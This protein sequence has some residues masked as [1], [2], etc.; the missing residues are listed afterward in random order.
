MP[1]RPSEPSRAERRLEWIVGG[2]AVD[3]IRDPADGERPGTAAPRHA[4]AAPVA[5]VV[6]DPIAA[7]VGGWVPRTSDAMQ[8]VRTEYVAEHGHPVDRA[9]VPRRRVRLAITW[10]AAGAAAVALAL[11]GGAVAVRAAS[12]AAGPAVV[13]PV[14]APRH[15]AAPSACATSCASTPAPPQEAASPA[16]VVV[17]VVGAVHDHGVVH[18]AAGARVSDAVAAAGGPTHDADLD[19]LNLARVLVDGEQLVVPRVGE[20]AAPTSAAPTE[21]DGGAGGPSIVDLNTAT[22][23]D[24]DALPGIGPVLAQ[25]IV[26]YRAEHP[27]GAVDELEDVPGI[28]PALLGRL[29]DLVRV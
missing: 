11:V 8:R 25:R 19:G 29:R 7:P 22:T 17:H 15:G 1:R 12:V 9:P 4:R 5:A 2:P 18:L 14:P 20:S 10:R 27:F 6:A 24:L 26:D 28:G 23:A 3:P 21:P 16:Q 13:L